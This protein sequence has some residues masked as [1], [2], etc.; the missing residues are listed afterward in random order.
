MMNQGSLQSL[1]PAEEDRTRAE[2][3]R[4][5]VAYHNYRYHTLDDPQI[6]DDEYNAAFQELVRLEERFPELRT[7]D[8]PT[9]KIG[10]QVLSAL[11]TR[12]NRLRMYS[13][14]NVFS[15]DE[16][17]GFL[18]RL[19]NAAP[20]VRPEFWCD[21]K[22]DGLAL[23][24]VY[25]R[26]RF[27]AALTRGD[28][29]V[30]EVVTE[31]MRTVRNLPRTLFGDA[32]DLL[33]VRGEVIFNRKDF[34]ELNARQ[35]K[36]GA[37]TF[38]NPRNAAAGSIRQ[39]DTSVTASRPLRFLAYGF[40]EVEWGRA[41]PWTTYAEVMERLRE[42]GFETPPDGRLCLSPDAVEAYYTS[43]R[44]G[45]RER[46]AYEIDGV[47]MK[48]NDLEMQRRLG[49]TA[50]APRFSVAWKFPAQQATT[51]LLDIT[52]Q[53]GR[54]GV[55]TPVAELHPV[56]VGGVVVSRATLHNE[57]EIINRDVRIGDRVIVQR[58]GDVIPEVV[59][60]VLSER[61]ADS[62]PFVFPHVCPACGEPAHRLEGEAAWRCVN[63]SC[64]AVIRQSL[65]H[66][67]SKAGLDIGGVGGRW[68]E[69]FISAGRVRTPA[70]LF[71]LTVD[72]LLHYERMGVKLA[73]KFVDSLERARRGAT[74]QRFICALGIRHVG[75][76][77]ARTLAAVYPDMDALRAASAE[78]L[79]ALP[80][81][82]PEVA[83][84]I[85]AFFEDEANLLLLTRLREQGLWP[86]TVEAPAAPSGVLRGKRVLFTGT[87]SMPRSRAQQLAEQAGAELAG[88]VSRKLDLLVAGEN[89]GS[90]LEKARAL[91]VRVLDEAGFAALLAGEREALSD[92]GNE[93][94]K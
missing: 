40:G 85:R 90:K 88:S 11:E 87:L 75:E 53:V 77:T 17:Q 82:G 47:V 56:T 64:P 55:L 6:T 5:F 36:A 74:L 44:D 39:L 52:I 84:S 26:G 14:D 15:T 28:G 60:A 19:D 32:P 93:V 61:P 25:E 24:L 8:S 23:E 18:K 27:A 30:G 78:E 42:Y 70:D 46:L 57:D 21:P 4:R 92:N 63:M 76:Q 20:G 51:E 31:A 2:E 49:Y 58:A 13:L 12:S 34:Q 94:T 10:G 91:G 41:T 38:A 54:T 50:R 65:A 81:I 86:V 43:L 48:L 72:E 68:I 33:E 83:S 79:Q 73:S 7:E 62:K 66:F 9:V 29:E 71:T 45:G 67:V 1:V 59:G 80:D 89:P 35:R 69:L 22:M 37:R 3:L 16:W